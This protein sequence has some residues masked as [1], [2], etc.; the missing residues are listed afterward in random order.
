MSNYVTNNIIS[1]LPDGAMN[2]KRPVPTS[3]LLVSL[4]VVISNRC[5][6]HKVI[7]EILTHMVHQICV[8]ETQL[9]SHVCNLAYKIRN[10]VLNQKKP[11][12]DL[13]TSLDIPS[14]VTALLCGVPFVSLAEELDPVLAFLR[15]SLTHFWRW[16]EPKVSTSSS[17]Q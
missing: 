1:L 4:Q 2:V 14:K 5:M 8:L 16:S 7:Q 9:R 6:D 3:Y 11:Y 10:I 13:G 12:I 15:S 17:S